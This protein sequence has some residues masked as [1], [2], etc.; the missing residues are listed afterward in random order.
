VDPAGHHAGD[1]RPRADDPRPDPRRRGGNRLAG[2]QREITA[3][4]GRE[5]SAAE[6]ARRARLPGARAR[7][8]LGVP[9]EP[10]SLEMPVVEEMPLGQV[11]EDTSV[12]PPTDTLL[13][14]DLG[15]QLSRMLDTL[16]PRERGVLILRFGLGGH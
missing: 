2:L 1:R 12:A 3:R 11:I 10:L 16:S 8:P 9:E 14:E 4:L 6:L 5:P 15:R 7:Q 13:T